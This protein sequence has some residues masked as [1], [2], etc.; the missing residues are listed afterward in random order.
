[1]GDGVVMRLGG[2]RV[3]GRGDGIR[4][5]NTMKNGRRAAGGGVRFHKRQA[6]KDH[7]AHPGKVFL[8]P[9]A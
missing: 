5:I 6:G 7:T 9:R 2:V 4:G 8:I 3:V 1:L